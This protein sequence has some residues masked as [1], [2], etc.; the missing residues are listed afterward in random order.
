MTPLHPRPRRIPRQERQQHPSTLRRV[1]LPPI[2]PAP[3]LEE[4]A[5]AIERELRR[6]SLL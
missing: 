6:G 5:D 1:A 4:Q 2:P 3:P